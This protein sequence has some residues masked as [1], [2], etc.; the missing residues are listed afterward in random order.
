MVSAFLSREL[1]SCNIE[2][3]NLDKFELFKEGYLNFQQHRDALRDMLIKH[4]IKAISDCY[5]RL[6]MPRIAK[7]I[8]VPLE[9]A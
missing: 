1:V 9:D 4:N 8:D 6:S 2:D 7:L 5:E 3:Y